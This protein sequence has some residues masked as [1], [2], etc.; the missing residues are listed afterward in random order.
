LR[1]KAERDQQPLPPQ[2][3]Q[4]YQKS[5][6]FATS[7]LIDYPNSRWVE[8]ALLLSQKV[9]YRQGN[10]AASTRKGHEL[11]ETF[12][13]SPSIPEC[14][15]YLAR[16]MLGLG[17]TVGAANEAGQAAAALEGT[18]HAEALLTQALAFGLVGDIDRA[19]A[20]FDELLAYEDTPR[21]ISIQAKL[22]EVVD[23]VAIT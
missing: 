20:L 23:D 16:G 21:D 7:V 3:Q 15:L 2:A 6:E 17:E 9:L 5:L 8:E 22:G 1:E 10:L 19:R 12:P 11:I 13:G 14:R 4:S 18:L